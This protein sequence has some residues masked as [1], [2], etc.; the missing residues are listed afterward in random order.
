[1]ISSFH[2]TSIELAQ[3]MIA[4]VRQRTLQDSLFYKH[5]KLLV[6]YDLSAEALIHA[7]RDP[8]GALMNHLA[9]LDPSLSIHRKIRCCQN[10]EGVLDDIHQTSSSFTQ[11]YRLSDPLASTSVIEC[12]HHVKTAFTSL[13]QEKRVPDEDSQ[14]V[15]TGLDHNLQVID[16]LT[17]VFAPLKA[18]TASLQELEL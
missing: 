12:H 10:I 13:R 18:L 15:I 8:F 4:S 2:T 16:E 1:M 6:D 3:R 17:T 14:K 9:Q 11:G 5:Q 7:V